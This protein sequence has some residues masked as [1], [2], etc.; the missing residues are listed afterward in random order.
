ME[1]QRVKG[2]TASYVPVGQHQTAP[3]EPPTVI[4]ISQADEAEAVLGHQVRLFDE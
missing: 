3:E 2:P 1:L 4:E